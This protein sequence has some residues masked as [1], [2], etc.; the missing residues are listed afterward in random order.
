MILAI[1][2]V[3]SVLVV[4]HELGH[5]LAAKWMGV[6]VEKFSIG[7]PPTIFSKKIGDTEFSISAIPLGGYVKLA[8]FIDE[9]MDSKVTGADDEFNSKPVW[10]RVV[11][12]T[13]G[14]IMNLFLAVAILTSL[15]YYQG[16][17]ILPYTTVG[18]VQPGGVASKIGFQENDKIVSVNQ[19][20]VD[21]W[22]QITEAFIDNLNSDITFNVIRDG[23]TV[24]LVY[25][26]EWFQD[27][28]GEQ[29]DLNPQIA[30][31]VGDVSSDMPAGQI[32]LQ[33][34]DLITELNGQ[35]V[36]DWNGMTDII[37]ANPDKPV[38][39]KWQRDGQTMS[40]EITPQAF[41]E[42]VDGEEID[43]GKIGITFYIDYRDVG[44]GTAIVNGFTNT[45]KMIALNIRGL[46]WVISGTKSASEIMGGPITIA[47]MAGDAADAGWLQLWYLIAVLSAV[48][49][50]FNILPIPALDGG[51]LFFILLEGIMRKPLPTKA[52]I[53]IQQIGMAILLTFIVLILYVDLKRMLF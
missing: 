13:A 19:A 10:R 26:K 35:P 49:A 23:Q 42:N 51:H 15:N 48:L 14:V 5:F 16:E 43:V 21:N 4:I 31:M 1:I 8:G 24:Q 11:I 40:A 44:I 38:S 22:N 37:R 46:W 53:K 9:S 45:Y 18:D 28:K 52:K 17:Q 50:F 6:R 27:R 47:K 7:F 25:K 34:G 41:T 20:E 2:F 36:R 32:G 30:S 3:F 39:I 12:I 29:L 33:K